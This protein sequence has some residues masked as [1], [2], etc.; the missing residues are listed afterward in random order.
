[1]YKI[2]LDENDV[3]KNWYNINADLPKSIPDY[4]DTPQG[5]L[6]NLGKIFPKE[7]I[8]QELSKERN[9]RIPKPVREFYKQIGRPTPL[10]RATRLEKLLD[11]PAKIFYK[12]ED[13]TPTGSHKINS[14]IAQAYYAK[15]NN[16]TKLT[17]ETGAGQ[18]GTALSL[19]CS[20]MDLDCLVY[21][22]KMSYNQ[23]PLRKQIIELYGGNILA[24]P[25]TNTDYG[26]NVLKKDPEHGGTLGI[27]I[28][29]AIEEAIENDNT[30]YS[31]GSVLNHV[32]LHQTIIG[33]ETKKQLEK[34]DI[35]PDMIIGCVGGG[36]NF[37]G[38]AFPFI[39]D[40]ISGKEDYEFIAVEPELCPSLTKGEYRY[41]YGDTCGLTP[42]IKMHSLGCDFVP[43]ELHVGGLRYHG[44][45]PQIS[46]LVEEGI[47]NARSV[48]QRD[49][50]EAGV[51]FARA[52][53]V[54]PAPETCHAI[55]ASIDEAIKCK[56]T[57]EEKNIVISFSGHGLIDLN[58]YDDFLNGQIDDI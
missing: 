41:D 56:K 19:A 31:I 6:K 51:T 34:E 54:V 43:P 39:K 27:A 52:E 4:L 42:K 38:M 37:G 21:M 35:K 17:T 3:P 15:K 46:L 29:E 40:K 10:Y 55:K 16:I 12:R 25:S 26:R 50:F 7:V 20:I 58:G 23:K 53:G 14:A 44:M 32:V 57:N 2:T 18:W 47:V 49:V 22:V 45:S 1:M 48:S 9:I 8:E 5:G 30:Y 11:T 13:T 24:S 28:S 33:L 36:T